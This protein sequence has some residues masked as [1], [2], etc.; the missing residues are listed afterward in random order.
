[1][2]D[3][4]G[5]PYRPNDRS[6]GMNNILKCEFEILKGKTLVSI[7]PYDDEL[8]FTTNSG[9]VYKLYHRQDCCENVYIDDID[10]DL[11]DLLHTPLLQA[12]EVVSY[13]LKAKNEELDPSYT[14]TFY[15]LATKNGYVTI[16]WYGVSN[17]YYSE[18]VDFGRMM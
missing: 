13:D 7:V 17:G 14:W 10:G 1:M 15:K 18:S 3:I 5:R 9:D 8:I 12:E 11:E 16:K 4:I 6:M 2:D